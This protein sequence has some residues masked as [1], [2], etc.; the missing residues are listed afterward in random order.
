MYRSPSWLM[1]F[2]P[3]DLGAMKNQRAGGWQ[4]EDTVVVTMGCQESVG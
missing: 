2:T 3:F 4:E 1:G